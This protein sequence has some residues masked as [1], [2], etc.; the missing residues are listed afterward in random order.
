M[1]NFDNFMF[2]WFVVRFRKWSKTLILCFFLNICLV[3]F[4]PKKV[5]INVFVNFALAKHRNGKYSENP[6]GVIWLVFN[7]FL[8]EIQIWNHASFFVEKH[9]S[10]H[11]ARRDR[12]STFFHEISNISWYFV[13]DFFK[14]SWYIWN[15]MNKC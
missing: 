9:I 8:T 12:I 13:F 4:S 6:R 3:T 11:R 2:F 1:E 14:I 15:F 5:K 7:R 10:F